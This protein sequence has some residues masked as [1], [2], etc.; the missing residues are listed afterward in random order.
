MY[1]LLTYDHNFPLKISKIVKT[2]LDYKSYMIITYCFEKS[3]FF[4]LA[5]FV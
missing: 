5:L 1:Q 4:V 2:I 3:N